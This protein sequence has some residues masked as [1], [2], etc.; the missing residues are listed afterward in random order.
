MTSTMLN[1]KNI[2]RILED[3]Q[4]KE[5]GRLFE[6]ILRSDSKQEKVGLKSIENQ[7]IQIMVDLD[8]TCVD[9]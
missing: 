4:Q 2:F 3:P 6:V 5:K 8:K 9:F 1:T 7:A